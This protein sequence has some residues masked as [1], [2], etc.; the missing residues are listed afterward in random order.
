MWLLSFWHWF[1]DLSFTVAV[2]VEILAPLLQD[3]PLDTHSLVVRSSATLPRSH[4]GQAW[5]AAAG[6]VLQMRRDQLLL[7]L[8]DPSPSWAGETSLHFYFASFALLC[9][10]RATSPA[11]PLLMLACEGT[12]C[13]GRGDGKDGPG[14][15][16]LWLLAQLRRRWPA[17]DSRCCLSR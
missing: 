15:R 4:L 9:Y 6:L 5:G 12:C 16:P 10:A 7:L 14:G 1:R 3:I 13:Q 8:T 17:G 11:L 2:R